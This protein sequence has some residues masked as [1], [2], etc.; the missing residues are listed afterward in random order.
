M[1]VQKGIARHATIHF[2]GHIDR[3]SV[4]V[5]YVHNAGDTGGLPDARDVD[6]PVAKGGALDRAIATVAR[7]AAKAAGKHLGID[8]SVVPDKKD[9]PAPSAAKKSTPRR[10]AKKAAE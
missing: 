4:N 5:Q 10:A 8:V 3:A 6:V 9:E 2:G 1:K 7:E